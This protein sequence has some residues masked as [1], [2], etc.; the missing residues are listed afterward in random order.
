MQEKLNI[1]VLSHILVSG[2]AYSRFKR[3]SFCTPPFCAL[4]RELGVLLLIDGW[5]GK[6]IQVLWTGQANGIIFNFV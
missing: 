2:Q 1:L 6:W 4:K 3:F 5:N